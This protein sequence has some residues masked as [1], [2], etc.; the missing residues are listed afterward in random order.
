M[1]KAGHPGPMHP[2]VLFAWAWMAVGMAVGAVLGLR[3]ATADWLGGY[4]SWERRLLRLGHVA[5]FGTGLLNLAAHGSL[6]ELAV[7]HPDIARDPR[8]PWSRTLFVIGAIGMPTICLAAARFRALRHLFVVPVLGLVGGTA[9]LL[10]IG[11]QP[12]TN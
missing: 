11:L 5:F 3:F 2:H 12:H 9:V 6:A 8:T 10:W 4:G 7:T 1:P